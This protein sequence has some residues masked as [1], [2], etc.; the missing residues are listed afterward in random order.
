MRHHKAA[1]I[2]QLQLQLLQSR[3]LS[4]RHLLRLEGKQRDA[5]EDHAANVLAYDQALQKIACTLQ[6]HGS[7]AAAILVHAAADYL[8]SRPFVMSCHGGLPCWLSG[9]L[10]GCL[11]MAACRHKSCAGINGLYAC[12]ASDW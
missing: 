10:A 3:M 1:G 7:S 12:N 4:L 8:D 11:L 6:T 5:Q 9:V 2:W